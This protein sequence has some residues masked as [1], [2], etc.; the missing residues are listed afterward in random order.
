MSPAGDL[1]HN[2]GVCPDQESN[3]Q[4]FS[5]QSTEAHQPRLHLF[6]V[7]LDPRNNLDIGNITV[8]F[9]M[10]IFPIL[11]CENYLGLLL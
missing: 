6:L 1:E 7:V 5:A 4:L 2:T 9:V 3:W 10:L 11:I 8:L